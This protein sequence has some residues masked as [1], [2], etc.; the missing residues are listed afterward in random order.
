MAYLSDRCCYLSL[1]GIFFLL[2]P[3]TYASSDR[4][5]WTH[6]AD[7]TVRE[8]Q[9]AEFRCS[10]EIRKPYIS[11][12]IVWTNGFTPYETGDH[13]TLLIRSEKNDS[14]GTLISKL[15]IQ[16]ASRYSDVPYMCWAKIRYLDGTS[17]T[18]S[19]KFGRLDVQ[20]FLSSIDMICT[21]STEI[22]YREHERIVAECK[23]PKGNPEVRLDF[24][25]S[26]DSGTNRIISSSYEDEGR[27][28]VL[29]TELD[30][31]RHIHNKH[32]Y[33]IATSSAFPG[34]KVN[35][36]VGP[37][38][39][40]HAPYVEVWHRRET[41][42][43]PLISEVVLFCL[44]SAFPKVTEYQWSCEPPTIV[45]TC[46]S[47]KKTI[48]LSL[49]N[50]LIDGDS[51]IIVK[52]SAKSE[53][54]QA[55]NTT[56][57]GIRYQNEKTIPACKET[58]DFTEN[59]QINTTT[60]SLILSYKRYSQYLTFQCTFFTLGPPK[61]P[62]V[63]WYFNGYI[64][65]N[66]NRE[67]NG[68][69]PNEEQPRWWKYQSLQNVAQDVKSVTCELTCPLKTILDASCSLGKEGQLELHPDRILAKEDAFLTYLVT[70]NSNSLID[71]GQ[72]RSHSVVSDTPK[73]ATT[74]VT[75]MTMGI[76][77]YS[78]LLTIAVIGIFLFLACAVLAVIIGVTRK[79]L[80]R[81]LSNPPATPS[82]SGDHD[83]KL[84]DTV[85]S[86]NTGYVQSIDGHAF[87]IYESPD[88]KFERH[89]G[90]VSNYSTEIPR[91]HVP[92]EYS[93][94]T[95]T[96]NVH[97][98]SDSIIS[99]ESGSVS[100]SA[101]FDEPFSHNIYSR[102]GDTSSESESQHSHIYENTLEN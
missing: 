31:A 47:A 76:G 23:A 54:G 44:T 87:P 93:N 22:G 29:H 17:D 65:D 60:D 5:R 71:Q 12:N 61:V 13:N 98:R 101:Y 40:F 59:I 69:M 79:I 62:E 35:C 52:C 68:E 26:V 1:L 20:Y 89:A 7:L 92:Q 78:W 91:L 14:M 25:L 51:S 46:N 82:K 2:R 73:I 90:Q 15:V 66:D 55:Q 50:S 95:V 100:S 96:M 58:N 9:S 74:Y 19:S 28:H 37:F 97:E 36:S 81:H 64:V 86:V 72:H 16:D 10:L 24:E 67:I 70:S 21:G 43:P 57:V 27:M 3:I 41:L 84:K 83:D 56:T 32:L 99:G 102:N 75:G 45:K 11:V 6:P 8:G 80:S 42:T 49:N 30:A 34:E 38:R 18:L 88:V 77:R 4:I 85:R 53:L 94:S 48:R 63:L 33:C 39:V